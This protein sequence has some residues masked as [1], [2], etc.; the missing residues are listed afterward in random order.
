MRRL[1]KFLNSPNLL[2]FEYDALVQPKNRKSFWQ[3][4]PTTNSKAN[5]DADQDVPLVL[6]LDKANVAR[7]RPENEKSGL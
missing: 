4:S 7:Q 2:T 3:C 5:P 1:L 6:M